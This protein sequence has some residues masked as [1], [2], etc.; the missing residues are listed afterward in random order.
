MGH[1]ITETYLAFFTDALK[2]VIIFE[3]IGVDDRADLL[4]LGGI[5][6]ELLLVLF[7]HLFQ[8]LE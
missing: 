1:L 8:L 7:D 4:V 3:E 6:P 5:I 2:F